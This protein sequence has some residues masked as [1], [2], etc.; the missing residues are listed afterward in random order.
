M[1]REMTA[2]CLVMALFSAQ[3]AAQTKVGTTIAQFVAIEPSARIAAMG[4]AGAAV[5][6]GIQ[7]VYYNPAALGSLER[8]TFQFSHGIWFA[9]IRH[10]YAAAAIALGD[11]GNTFVSVTSLNS[12]DIEVRTVTQPL[13]TGELYSVRDVAL[14]VGYGRQVTPRFAAG[15]Q[16]NY[17]SETI[18]NSTLDAFSFSFGTVYRITGSGL[19][20]GASVLHFGTKSGFDG[21]DLVI[22]YDADPTRYGDNSALPAAQATDEF[23]VPAQF[24]IGLSYPRRLSPT[25]KLLLSMDAFHPNDNTEGVSLG[26]EWSWKETLALR[27]GYQTLGQQDTELGPTAGIGLSGV[28]ASRRFEFDYGWASHTVLPEVHRFTF[29]LGM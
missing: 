29:V 17:M 13:G 27:A 12:G 14:S 5:A 25:S 8:T 16:F 4:N 2:A 15:A 10:E 7:A 22:Q 9:D 6:E 1:R 28:I 21:R 23:P 18:W 11:W 19:T 26:W 24:R 20:L 3:A